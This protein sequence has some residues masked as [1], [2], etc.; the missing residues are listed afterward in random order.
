MCVVLFKND[1]D[2]HEQLSM[3]CLQTS[4]NQ[5]YK[6]LWTLTRLAYF[7]CNGIVSEGYFDVSLNI[8]NNK[9]HRKMRVL[10]LP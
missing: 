9:E 7:V 8:A 1:T 4:K 5:I 10:D 2:I 3:N 6:A